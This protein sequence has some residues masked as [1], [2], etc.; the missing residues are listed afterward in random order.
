MQE[1]QVQQKNAIAVVALNRM[2]KLNAITRAMYAE[3]LSVMTQLGEDDSVNVII[4]T[5]NGEHFSA[6]FDLGEPPEPSGLQHISNLQTGPNALRWSIWDM[7]KPVIGA[8]KGY[9][10]GGACELA[11]A[12]DIVMAGDDLQIGEPE[13]LFG[14]LPAFLIVP[15][16]VG[17]QRA[18]Y[19]LLS[20]K[21]FRSSEALELGL[22]SKVVPV[23]EL[24]DF[25]LAFAQELSSRP[26]PALGYLKKAINRSIEVQGMRSAI[27]MAEE[28]SGVSHDY[29]K[30]GPFRKRVEAVGVKQALRELRESA[31]TPEE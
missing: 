19:I 28:M 16:L 5:G 26:Q 13:I 15:W 17:P 21:R 3:L 20:G 23:D 24:E 2:A 18:K 22:V 12:C 31:E 29:H 30:D 10:L 14:V 7:A 27:T 11:L 1:I 9:C 6:G 25:V 4:L 8:I